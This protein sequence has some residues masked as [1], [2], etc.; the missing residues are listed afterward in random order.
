MYV[1]VMFADEVVPAC[2]DQLSKPCS[3]VWKKP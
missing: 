3:L 2:V 1:S